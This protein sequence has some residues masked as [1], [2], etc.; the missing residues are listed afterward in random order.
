MHTPRPC[1]GLR[2]R[3]VN[4]TE[5]ERA[6]YPEHWKQLPGET[7]PQYWARVERQDRELGYTPRAGQLFLSP[8]AKANMASP[9]MAKWAGHWGGLLPTPIKPPE[10]TMHRG[11]A[12]TETN[13]RRGRD[14]AAMV[15]L[16][17][18]A[19][20]EYGSNKGGAAGRT[21]PE[22][23]SLRTMLG[24]PTSALKVR[25]AEHAEGRA[26]NPVELLATPTKRDWRSG[27]ASEATHARNS[28]PL[29]E[30]ACARGITG[31]A[32]LLT[33]VEWMMGFPPRWLLDAALAVPAS[34]PT[35]MRSSPN[36]PTAS[37]SRSTPGTATASS[38]EEVDIFA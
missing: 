4:Q 37:R 28:R 23:P 1:S 21:G 38:V 9:S 18:P 14:L 15:L 30:Q 8:T 16:P 36:S 12:R 35:A 24:T 29:S 10:G 26:S 17:A 3:G 27:K 6:L 32:A 22:R 7:S 31:T 25:S 11:Y 19:A 5:L 20:T 2:S 34:P 13:G 33:L